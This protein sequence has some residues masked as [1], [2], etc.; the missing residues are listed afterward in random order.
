M[1]RRRFLRALV[2]AVGAGILPRVGVGADDDIYDVGRFGNV[3][4]LHITDTHAQLKPVHY[5]EPS[6]NIGVGTMAGRP[7]HLVGRAFLDHFGIAPGSRG[8]YAFT[9]LDYQE[10]AQRYGRIGGFAH[11]KTL[12][13]RLGA[14]AGAGNFLLLD[15][16]DAWQ[17]SGLSRALAGADMVEA[18]NLLGVHAMT[19]HW[20]F[21]HGE[22]KLRRNL[23]RF[24][25]E[26]LA[27][28]VSL[29]QDAA[30]N[31][32][33][34]FDP[35]SGRV[36][37]P[38]IIKE[39]GGRRIG[40][41]GQAFPYVPVAH[42]KRFVPDWTFG[43]REAELQKFVTR[44]REVDGVDA[45]LLLSHNG[46][47]ADLKLAGRIA[48]IDVIL[49]GHT[50]DAVPE[51]TVVSNI[52][53]KTAVTNAGSSGKFVAVVDLDIGS[54]HVKDLR[55]TLL[56]VF[57]GLI[58]PDAAMQALID[59]LRAPHAAAFDEPLAIAGELLYRRGNFGGPMDQVICDAL[60]RELDAQIALSPGFR[61]GG[62]V[63]AG[64]SIAMDDLLSQTAISYPEVY[65]AEMT[66]SQLKAVLEDVADNLF[67]PDPYY[68]Q[69]GDMVRVG[70]MDY[71]C[72]PAAAAGSR[73][74]DMTLDDGTAVAA[75]KRYRV[76]GWAALEPQAG[77]PVSD[78]VAAYLRAEKT[79][80]LTRGN[81][82][83]I[84]GVA[85]NPG[86]SE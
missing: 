36:F 58:A 77:K 22:E 2:A 71:A 25:G 15:G 47:D 69:G 32:A 49:G 40:I 28:N 11:L 35:A 6:V 19:G 86:I 21:T 27:Q 42:P 7:P 1:H 54:K 60:R 83:L 5:R 29:T 61:F 26:F 55:Y 37:K 78:V 48:G 45:V 73:I 57:A 53:G 38:A 56:P 17:G 9:F 80:R 30:F 20:E 52:G 50:H 82:V 10:A 4:V 24:T 14:Q 34:A 81:R 46:M 33:P 41:I 68:Q 31:D 18:A 43:L 8:A 72:A 63:L 16:G 23:E 79:V 66:G 62:A 12:I 13:D 70:G 39:V 75:G 74:S 44:L 51:P 3:R 76:A 67:N 84:K 59:R 85:D 65:V 64:E